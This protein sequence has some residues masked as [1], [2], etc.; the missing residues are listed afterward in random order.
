M[1]I[2]KKAE[3]GLT[4]MIHLAKNKNKKAVSI[5]EISNI[6]A[7]PFEF[8]S[9][10]FSV[11]EKAKLVTA[12]HG[13]NGGYILAKAPQ[14]ISANDVVSVLETNKQGADCAL[15]SRKRKCLTKTVWAKVEKA[16]HKTLSEITLAN[17]IK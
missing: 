15:C 3:Y 6:E 4:A 11:L 1:K 16:L 8:L 17:L 9:K 12:K 13:A 14:R 2:S 5:R 7:V 10:I